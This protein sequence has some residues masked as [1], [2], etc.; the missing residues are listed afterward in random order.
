MPEIPMPPDNCPVAEQSALDA[1][2][3]DDGLR[4]LL[5]TAMWGSGDQP[6][7]AAQIGGYVYEI[8]HRAAQAVEERE[9]DLRAIVARAYAFAEEMRSYCSPHGVAADY[10][11]R[12]EVRLKGEPADG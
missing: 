4:V 3:Y 1:A 5:V 8:A 11:N 10:A 7:A 9:Q 12:L 6:T 2:R